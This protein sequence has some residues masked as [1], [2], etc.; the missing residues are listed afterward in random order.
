[1]SWVESEKKS[2]KVKL[3]KKNVPGENLSQFH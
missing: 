3:I 1:M 2:F